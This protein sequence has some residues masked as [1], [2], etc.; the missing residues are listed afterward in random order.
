[1]PLNGA[2]HKWGTCVCSRACAGGRVQAGVCK[3]ACA[4][5]CVQ[6][7]ACWTP[8]CPLWGTIL[9]L[10]SDRVGCWCG[11]GLGRQNPLQSQPCVPSCPVII[12][13]TPRN[14]IS[15]WEQ[16]THALGPVAGEIWSLVKNTSQRVSASPS[17]GSSWTRAS[18][19]GLSPASLGSRTSCPAPVL[20]A[21]WDAVR[22]QTRTLDPAPHA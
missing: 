9:T 12:P 11:P 17:A 4:G 10:G 2:W 16:L 1:M 6:S 7:C 14:K 8:P 22:L 19:K 20:P 18:G 5:V 21:P 3:R 15:A 13:P